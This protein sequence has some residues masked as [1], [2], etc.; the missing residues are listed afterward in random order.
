MRKG[1]KVQ[2]HSKHS[3]L[4]KS[5]SC[6]DEISKAYFH[7]A[8][9]CDRLSALQWRY[10]EHDGVSYQQ[11]HNCLLNRLFRRTSK[12]I[13]KLLVTGLCAG[14]SPVTGEFPAQRARNAE[15]IS[16]WWRHHGQKSGRN[17]P[18][19]WAHIATKATPTRHLRAKAYHYVAG[20]Q[21]SEIMYQ[22]TVLKCSYKQ[23]TLELIWALC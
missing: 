3:W 6:Q 1:L 14:N 7:D 19:T 11:P 15:N 16:I 9:K 22:I 13:S 10:Y 8:W 4:N 5:I 17:P 12:K 2:Y 20:S 23:H 21:S 18:V